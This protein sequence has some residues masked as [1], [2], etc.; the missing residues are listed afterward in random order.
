MYLILFPSF[1]FFFVFYLRITVGVDILPG[2]RYSQYKI[3][4]NTIRKLCKNKRRCRVNNLEEAARLKDL[5]PLDADKIVERARFFLRRD[6]IEDYNVLTKNCEHF[7]T[8]CRY[9]EEFSC[10]VNELNFISK[11][12]VLIS[13]L[14]SSQR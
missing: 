10:Q 11:A 13:T 5:K 9:G 3:R 4:E 8:L 7:A 14:G 1:V 6:L 2:S 12:I